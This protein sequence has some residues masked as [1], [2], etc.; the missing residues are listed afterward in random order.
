[1]KQSCLKIFI[2]TFGIACL[3]TGSAQATSYGTVLK[4]YFI[5]LSMP[6]TVLT[7]QEASDLLTSTPEVNEKPSVSNLLAAQKF[8]CNAEKKL[9]KTIATAE[10]SDPDTIFAALMSIENKISMPSTNNPNLLNDQATIKTLK[11]R[12]GSDGLFLGCYLTNQQLAILTLSD[13]ERPFFLL[14]NRLALIAHLDEKSEELPINEQTTKQLAQDLEKSVATAKTTIDQY[15]TKPEHRSTANHLLHF[16]TA[17]TAALL[18]YYL[19]SKYLRFSLYDMYLARLMPNLVNRLIDNRAVRELTGIDTLHVSIPLKIARGIA[20]A[21]KTY[22]PTAAFIALDYLSA[23][24]FELRLIHDG[25]KTLASKASWSTK[26]LAATA[27][28]VVACPPLFPSTNFLWRCRGDDR[29]AKTY[30][31]R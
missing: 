15:T 5:R 16:A 22:L 28:G 31:T 12:L 2:F 13:A 24:P 26:L 8:I 9:N 19:Y 4:N 21:Y 23:G 25:L 1:M 14:A 7:T 11:K 27:S 20:T 29:V 10:Y 30:F 3:I 17:G 6:P 18:S